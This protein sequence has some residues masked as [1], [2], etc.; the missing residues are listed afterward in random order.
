MLGKT[1]FN[2]NSVVMG[3]AAAPASIGSVTNGRYSISLINGVEYGVYSFNAPGGITGSFVVTVGGQAEIYSWGGGGGGGGAGGWSYG[4]SPGAGGAAY[5][6]ARLS[7]GTYYVTAG[8]QGVYASTTSATGGGG[9]A[10][11][12]GVDNR[13]GGGGGGYSGVFTTN[14]NLQSSAVVIAG[15]GGGGGSSRAGGGNVGGAGGGETGQNGV[16]PY[17]GKT[18][19]AGQGG[20]QSSAGA[21]ASSD[22]ANTLGFQ[23]ALQ[24]GSP[25][26][27]AYGGAGGGGY[28]GGSAGGYTEGNTMG[29]GGGGS[30]F[31]NPSFGKGI[32]TTGNLTIAGD[33]TNRFRLAAGNSDFAGSVLVVF[34]IPPTGVSYASLN[35]VSSSNVTV[36]NNGTTSVD[37]FKTSGGSAWDSQAYTTNSFTAPCTLEFNKAAA[38]YDNFLSYIM[39]GFNTDPTANAS[40]DTLDYAAFPYRSDIYSVYHNSAQVHFATAWSPSAKFYI[41]YGTDGT[42]KHYNGS[43]LLYNVNYGTGNTVYVDTSFATIDPTFSVFTN[44]RVAR[45]TWTGTGYI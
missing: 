5:I 26:T 25:R 21:D 1:R 14:P 17:D 28:W 29:G 8:G 18:A 4:A 41:V 9:I 16:A 2:L 20:T 24:G 12:N 37:M 30:G 39:I 35:F 13:Y 34:K 19:Y 33:S 27:N 36:T 40:Y 32:L 10:S 31:I 15:G 44:V 45:A 3:G 42:I 11:R 6:S 22:S 7:A 43:T 23:G 38:N